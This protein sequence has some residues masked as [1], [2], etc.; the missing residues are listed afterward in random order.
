V[1]QPQLTHS[2]NAAEPQ[3]HGEAGPNVFPV[4]HRL[5]RGRYA[6]AVLLAAVLGPVGALV[7]YYA[8]PRVYESEAMIQVAPVLPKILYESEENSMLPMFDAF[9]QTQASLIGSDRVRDM[10][11]Q[12]PAW[13]DA[14]QGN[15]STDVLEF[16]ENLAV[17]PPKNSQIIVVSYKDEDPK[18]AQAI[19]KAV[20][21][22]YMSIYGE[23]NRDTDT[24]RFQVLEERAKALNSEIEGIQAQIFEIANEYG[25]DSLDM[26]FEHKVQELQK[27]ETE[28]EA[29]KLQLANLE[30]S[31][32][33]ADAASELTVEQIAAMDR[34]MQLLVAERSNAKVRLEGIGAI[35][36]NPE[37]RLEYRRAKK[38]LELREDEVQQYA[39]AFRDAYRSGLTN[40]GY[41]MNG[42]MPVG[43]PVIT[44]P[45]SAKERVQR[46][47]ALYDEAKVA[48]L[49]LGRKNLKI[50]ELRNRLASAQ[51]RLGKT[52]T[53][54]EQLSVEN[55]VGGRIS[56]LSEAE[57]PTFPANE[58][59]LKQLAVLGGLAGSGLGVGTVLLFGLFNPRFRYIADAEVQHPR[60]LGALPEL[61]ENTQDP[62]ESLIAAQCVHQIRMVLQPRTRS[63][64][65]RVL[66]VTS[67]AAGSGKT[68]LTLALALSFAASGTRT[69]VIDGDLTGMGLTRRTRDVARR[70]RA[71][72]FLEERTPGDA[73]PALT[74][75]VTPQSEFSA[76]W[77]GVGADGIG[78]RDAEEAAGTRKDFDL[79]LVDALRGEPVDRCLIYL[80]L[81]NL[82]ILPARGSAEGA[83]NVV[84]RAA[85]S[86]LIDGLRRSYE[87]ILIDSGPVPGPMDSSVM[88]SSADGV[89]MVASRGEHLGMVRQAIEHLE[90]VQA[91]LAG[92][93]FNR[94]RNRDLEQSRHSSAASSTR[95]RNSNGDRSGGHAVQDTRSKA[96]APLGPLAQ[97][98]WAMSG[99]AAPS[100]DAGN[101]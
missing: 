89:V 67:A 43:L 9:I 66:T 51:D 53:R 74:S 33:G 49:D 83:L 17:T 29:A 72:L 78:E 59:R 45:K 68:S 61:P 79:G 71:E 69:L 95:S 35:Y 12:T 64:T 48:T 58:S 92:V 50:K 25:S 62:S 82:C 3:P 73:E 55:V 13:K 27:M 94:A 16:E 91:P 30:S 85:M 38:E 52:E 11:M 28:L 81:P 24:Q 99:I 4:V 1:N 97:A 31:K 88:A 22:A 75:V 63:E 70:K 84:S 14:H 93:V 87:M 39:R 15:V 65:A 76:G 37:E 6:L 20:V 77:D 23:R 54:M 44:D 98:V 41:S 42:A 21:D 36:A 90:L 10:A 57:L 2:T 101:G 47:Q 40:N 96:I 86:E 18:R 100:A 80:D 19:A 26:V 32:G 56:L 8:L 34:Q 60:L 7:G 46:I 5:L